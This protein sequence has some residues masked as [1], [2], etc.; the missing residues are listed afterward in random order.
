[1]GNL[2]RV[3]ST[4]QTRAKKFLPT[5]EKK[6]VDLMIETTALEVPATSMVRFVDSDGVKGLIALCLASG[7]KREEV[8]KMIGLEISEINGMVTN[9][10]IM[11]ARR[12]M[13]NAVIEAAEQKVMRDLL[14]GQVTEE[15]SR[16]DMIVTRRRKLQIDAHA[17]VRMSETDEEKQEREKKL[18]GR[19]GVDRQKG[20]VIEAEIVKE[21]K[22]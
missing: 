12:R 17:E 6:V 1:M 5:P 15:T 18:L 10:D 20:A 8:A 16:A 22:K 3:M 4:Q 14:N 11:K 7:H 21:E 9:E 13:P 2:R 19:F